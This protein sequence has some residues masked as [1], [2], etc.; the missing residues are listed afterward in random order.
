MI[1]YL[2]YRILRSWTEALM[3]FS[4]IVW[5][6]PV[7]AFMFGMNPTNI[8]LTFAFLGVAAVLG[9]IGAFFTHTGIRIL[10][11]FVSAAISIVLSRL[12]NFMELDTGCLVIAFN[13]FYVKHIMFPRFDMPGIQLSPILVLSMGVFVLDIAVFTNTPSL[14]M[15]LPVL[16]WCVPITLLGGMITIC[17]EQIIKTGWYSNRR[18]P[19]NRSVKRRNTIYFVCISILIALLSTVTSMYEGVN[20]FVNKLGLLITSVIAFLISLLAFIP[21]ANTG[22]SGTNVMPDITGGV[23]KVSGMPLALG[24]VQLSGFAQ[25]V[26][27]FFVIAIGSLLAYFI[28]KL[29]KGVLKFISGLL[30]LSKETG[31]DIIDE[32]D[33]IYGDGSEFQ[34]FDALKKMWSNIKNSVNYKDLKSNRERIRFIYKK[35]IE[36]A[37]QK[38]VIIPKTNTA[39][40]VLSRI[41]TT[42]SIWSEGEIFFLKE[43]YQDVRYGDIEVQ[44][45]IVG[46]AEK[47]I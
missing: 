18:V 34:G 13:S 3:L 33:N 8:L 15:Y 21:K 26:L 46:E 40:E 45:D 9:S 4:I 17:T 2:P 5:L 10:L 6:V 16:Y 31:E 11:F 28:F 41:S 44:S 43:A 14:N 20:Y 37:K 32:E 38:G 23:G 25:G 29:I 27:V 42:S 22:S 12:F 24:G 19:I 39:S 1:K 47:L 35:V 30:I 36:R 7:M